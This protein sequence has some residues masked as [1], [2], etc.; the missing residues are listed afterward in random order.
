MKNSLSYKGFSAR[1]EFDA[2]DNI[3][4]GRVL[5]VEDIIGFHGETVKELTEDFHNAINHYL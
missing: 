3:F 4:F 5:G 2:D 1:V